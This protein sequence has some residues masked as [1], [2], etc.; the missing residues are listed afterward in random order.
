MRI[1]LMLNAGS[2]NDA[3][4]AAYGSPEDDG[5]RQ[6]ELARILR[7]LADDLAAGYLPI[8]PGQSKALL[9]INGNRVGVADVY[10]W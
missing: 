7:S 2:D 6:R 1:N 8:E 10:A 5:T 9:D 3:F 4:G